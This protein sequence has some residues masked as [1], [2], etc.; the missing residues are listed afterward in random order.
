MTVTR[1]SRDHLGTALVGAQFALMGALALWGTPSFLLG[2][3]PLVA[4]AMAAVGAVL[5]L[6]TLTHNR[7]GNFNIRPTPREGGKVKRK[8]GAGT[9]RGRPGP[10]PGA[11]HDLR[12]IERRVPHRNT[13]PIRGRDRLAWGLAMFDPERLLGQMIGGALGGAFGGR[14]GRRNSAFRTGDLAGKAQL[15]IGLLGIAMAAWEHYQQPRAPA[16]TPGAAGSATP[17]P[18]PASG[19]LRPP[20][21]P[22][23]NPDRTRDMALLV[24][25][26]VA[27]AAADG[28]IDAQERER[29]LA[30]ATAS[31]LDS[32]SQAF[33]ER[34]LAAPRSLEQ[35]VAA[36]RPALAPDLYAASLI[37]ISA[38][39]EAERAY[40]DRLAQ[41]LSLPTET[42]AAIHQQLGQPL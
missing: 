2:R 16:A 7:P 24:Q 25:A 3:A 5:G 33:L 6:W 37:A 20:P 14:R 30:R 41:A 29:I 42:R 15:G 40:L 32:D 38:D 34:E 39:T 4:W 9:N 18:A 35:I 12:G 21:P 11:G 22:A 26:M 23:A 1:R 8:G 10:V 19:P 17:P 13:K 27:A 36:A 28:A 31:G